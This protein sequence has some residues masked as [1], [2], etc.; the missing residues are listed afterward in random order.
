M[1]DTNDGFKISEVD[2]Q[3]RGPGNM[4]GTQQS[5]SIDLRIANL[6]TDGPII[7]EARKCAL[8]ILDEDPNLSKPEHAALK[9][10]Y[11]QLQTSNSIWRKIS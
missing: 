4:E 10:F 6:A 9:S 3:L 8:E 1:C 7:E 5:G 2:L 11:A